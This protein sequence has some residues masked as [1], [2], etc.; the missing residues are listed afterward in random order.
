MSN[1]TDE[2]TLPFMIIIYTDSLLNLHVKGWTAFL[3]SSISCC[4]ATDLCALKFQHWRADSSTTRDPLIY[5]WIMRPWA[6]LS[7]SLAVFHLQCKATSQCTCKSMS[8]QICLKFKHKDKTCRSKMQ[9]WGGGMKRL[10]H[11]SCSTYFIHHKWKHLWQRNA[12]VA[13]CTCIEYNQ[14]TWERKY[15]N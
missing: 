10:Y 7:A 14:F 6:Q 12:F 15:R 13:V 4:K 9:K 11:R 5:P 8:P 2:Q 1:T 3:S